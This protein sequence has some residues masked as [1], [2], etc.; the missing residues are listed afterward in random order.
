M[1]QDSN[2]SCCVILGGLLAGCNQAFEQAF[3]P[4][5]ASPRT[6]LLLLFVEL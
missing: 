1:Y 6:G 2:L 5:A 3:I 4:S